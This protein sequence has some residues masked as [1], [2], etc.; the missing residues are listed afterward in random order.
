MDGLQGGAPMSRLP[1]AT[2]PSA[3]RA[4]LE[5]EEAVHP[6]PGQS[7]RRSSSGSRT[8]AERSVQLPGPQRRGGPATR[9]DHLR[10]PTTAR[11]PRSPTGAAGPVKTAN[12]LKARGIRRATASSSTCRCHRRH[13]RHA[14]L[15]RIGATHS[16]GVRRLLGA[17][18]C[19]TAS[20]CRR[21]AVITAD[22]QMRG[23]KAS[24]AQVHRRRRP[25]HGRLPDACATSSSTS[26]PAARTPGGGATS[27]CTR[28]AGRPGR[29]CEPSGSDAEHPL[30][31]LYTSGSTG[32][33]KGVQHST[34][35]Y[36]LHAALTTKWTF[37][38]K[39]GR[40]LLV[41]G[42]HRLGHRPHLHHLRPWP[43]RHRDRLRRRA[44]LPGRRPL[45]EDDP[46]PQGHHLLH[47]AHGDPLA[48]QGGRNQRGGAPRRT[49]TCLSLRIW[50]RWASRSTRPPGMWYHQRRRRPLPHRRHLLADRDRRPT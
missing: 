5:L 8:A 48:D 36:L 46:G 4:N 17:R 43:G 10:K 37:D 28:V 12:A 45:L 31:L 15:R 16:G 41:H 40:R 38:I 11:S 2:G 20:G 13:G 35:G 24:A 9:R 7:G 42:R 47:G 30:F 29:T 6:G 3:W 25:G 1:K 23:G 14:G 39:A 49:T 34:G 22:E 27:G 32:K 44:D 33:P 19:A 26:A 18:A 50:A 21:R